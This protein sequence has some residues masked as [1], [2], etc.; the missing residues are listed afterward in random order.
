MAE[1]ESRS[2]LS[3]KG[4]DKTFYSDWIAE[5]GAVIMKN[6]KKEFQ[7]IYKNHQNRT[8]SWS[9]WRL[10]NEQNDPELQKVHEKHI[11][12][13]SFFSKFLTDSIMKFRVW[14]PWSYFLNPKD[15][16]TIGCKQMPE[17]KECKK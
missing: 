1:S 10:V 12:S 14:S 15:R 6:G 5:A 2:F 4:A 3:L 9:Y 7:D 8:L 17:V 16:I 13:W 11:R